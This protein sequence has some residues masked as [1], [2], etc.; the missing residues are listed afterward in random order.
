M[1]DELSNLAERL[2]IHLKLQLNGDTSI[3][4]GA[5][6]PGKEKLIVYVHKKGLIFNLGTPEPFEGHPVE[7]KY[8]GPIRLA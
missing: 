2:R 5:G 1:E 3:G 8:T 4:I 6:E 7:F